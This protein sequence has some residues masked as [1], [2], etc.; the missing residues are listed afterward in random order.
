MSFAA[1]LTAW[2]SRYEPNPVLIKETRQAVRSR[3]LLG[4]LCLVLL[5]LTT[6]SLLYLALSVA[7]RPEREAG[8]AYFTMVCVILGIAQLM[9]CGAIF[10]RTHREREP[11]SADLLFITTLTPGTI[12]RG[13][14]VSGLLLSA[15]IL[16][17]GLPFITSAY[18]L[19][20][21]DL[22]TLLGGVLTLAGLGLVATMWA[23]L[24][25]AYAGSQLMKHLLFIAP[26]GFLILGPGLAFVVSSRGMMRMAGGAA[27]STSTYTWVSP[28]AAT[29]LG[30]TS[31]VL[32]MYAVAVFLLSPPTAN[33]S[34]PCRMML[35][36]LIVAWLLTGRAMVAWNWDDTWLVG[37]F[38]AVLL[39]MLTGFACGFL[40]GDELSRRVRADMPRPAWRR[41]TA[42]LFYNGILPTLLWTA[43]VMIVLTAWML[44]QASQSPTT[45]GSF[46]GTDLETLKRWGIFCGYLLV[47]GLLARWVTAGVHRRFPRA[48]GLPALAFLLILI[49][50][51]TLGSWLVK[52]VL[53]PRELEL[54]N[55][56]LPGNIFAAMLEN[57]CTDFAAH[58]AVFQA[59]AF[60]LLLIFNAGWLRT[61]TAQFR[62]APEPVDHPPLP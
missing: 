55:V 7:A 21:V 42:L 16:S 57:Q 51:G 52:G 58:H 25:A 44:Y 3:A 23:I 35:T 30:L 45:S 53:Y 61:V 50:V 31:L 39:L 54:D 40:S 12:V 38:V 8:S 2:C 28:A 56:P 46:L 37:P 43:L 1:R 49:A 59:V 9:A 18:L 15:L 34:Q 26:V 48:A 41:A 4:V 36:G 24:T 17:A 13:K 6:A 5:V 47:Y 22:L 11:G 29:T 62:R 27:A 32:A 33:R 10:W 19:R 14:L 60:T 20:G